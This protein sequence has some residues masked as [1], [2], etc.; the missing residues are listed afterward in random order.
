LQT[1]GATHYSQ[2]IL[3]GI[4]HQPNLPDDSAG[5]SRG[6]RCSNS[7]FATHAIFDRLDE[8]FSLSKLQDKT[9]FPS[10]G[11]DRSDA[12]SCA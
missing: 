7:P 4:R 12:A 5:V 2:K 10:N 6:G 11:A 9:A 1:N 8:A 3:P